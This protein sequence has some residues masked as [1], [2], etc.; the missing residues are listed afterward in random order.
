[1]VK[2]SFRKALSVNSFVS[3]PEQDFEVLRQGVGQ[4]ASSR[5]Q[6]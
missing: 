5:T 2:K 3:K 4:A 1:M 6:K